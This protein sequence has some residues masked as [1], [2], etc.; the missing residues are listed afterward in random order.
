MRGYAVATALEMREGIEVRTGE[1]RSQGY[2][3][4]FRM[5]IGIDTGN[6]NVGNSGSDARLD[7]TIIGGKANLAPVQKR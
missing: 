2:E 7:D 1:W 6:C 3:R 5:R 4:P